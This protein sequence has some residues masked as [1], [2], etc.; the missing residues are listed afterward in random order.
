MSEYDPN[1]TSDGVPWCRDECRQHDGKRC[2]L[3]GFRPDSLCE[4]AVVAMAARLA[5]L[6]TPA[7]DR[8]TPEGFVKVRAAVSVD[9]DCSFAVMGGS[10]LDDETVMSEIEP[11]MTR[12]SAIHFITAVV[13]LPRIEEIEGEV[14]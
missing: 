2:R 9:P 4:P 3:L 1:V 13:P 5:E 6:E 10:G 8:S 7:R 11:D 12:H 14:E